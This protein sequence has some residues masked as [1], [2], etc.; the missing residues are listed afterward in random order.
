MQ[1]ILCLVA[2]VSALVRAQLL[3]DFSQGGWE[4]FASTPGTLVV[5]PGR[6]HLQDADEAPDW[7]TASKRFSVDLDRHPLFLVSV[8][9]LSDHGTVKLI[10]KN[11]DDKRTVLEMGSPGLYVIDLTKRFGW[12]GPCEIDVC[13][14]AVGFGESIDYAYVQFADKLSAE[15]E[16]ALK[17]REDGRNLKL[18]VTALEAVPLFNACAFYF[19]SPRR[20]SLAVSY[21]QAGGPWQRAFAPPYIAEDGM[22]RG[23]IVDL[24]ENTAY[25]LRIADGEGTVLAETAFRTWASEVPVART[26]VLD[27]TNFDGHLQIRE[28]GSPEGWIRYTA[29]PGFV[30]R[31]DRSG[32][33]L[34]LE[35][36][37]YILLDGLTLRGGLKEAI[38]IR[39]CE[40]VRVQ[41]CDIAGWGR[42]GTQ[43]FDRDGVFYTAEGA[44][45]NWDTAIL[46]SR[47]VGTV[48]E[49]CYV[50]DP[51]S[52]ANSWYYSH[53]AGPQAVGIDK[54]RSTVLRYNDFIGSDEHRWNDAVEGSGNFHQDG[55]FFR[56]ADIYGNLM[57]FAN[58]DAIEID[59]GQ[60]NVRVH[61]NL[62][63]GCLCGVSIQGCM[64]GPSYVF[65]N[66]LKN[67]GDERGVA[68]QT[69]K[70][71]SNGSGKSA[72]S[73]LFANSS[74][75]TGSD[76]GLLDHLRIVAKN[77]IFAGKR[78]ITG[79]Q[80]SPQSDCDYNLNSTGEA[81]DEP[82]GL[83]GLPEFADAA[84]GHF[85][86]A[87]GSNLLG[88]GV[89]IDNFV[90]AV[91]GRVDLGAIPAGSNL[92]LP[93][94]PIPVTLDRYELRVAEAD[95]LAGRSSTVTAAVGGEGFSSPFRIAKNEVFDW[96]TV[97]PESGTLTAGGR[98]TFTVTPVPGKAPARKHLRGAFLVRLENGFSRPVMVYAE[99]D[100]VPPV[101]PPAG[102][103]WIAYL[104]AEA[105]AGER[106][107]AVVD[108]PAASGGKC[109]LVAGSAKDAP[110][111]YRFQVPKDGS[112]IFLMRV[113][114]EESASPILHFSVD[115]G[116]QADSRLRSDTAWSWSMLAHNRQQRLTCHQ[117]FKLKAGE[118]VLRL[119]P[120]GSLYV[121]LIAVTD[122][123]GVFE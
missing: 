106:A 81:G 96:F 54:P 42:I 45:I 69:I 10:R 90:P 16:A 87:E 120:G 44:A 71:S 72:V 91:D 29:K 70:T 6:L 92:V 53:P 19:P 8:T 76:L 74:H 111:E 57:C 75:N 85:A 65:R 21:R 31:N 28:S 104:E 9:A 77:N 36:A 4:R 88:R 83:I 121:D 119:V 25:E 97:T 7:V 3:D 117:P 59:G 73:F 112:Y 84:A 38:A 37:K 56:D 23:S 34:E 39:R 61:R 2:L 58:D 98:V 79:R 47:S 66:L 51:V 89:A 107:F 13:L 18:N 113:R 33:L 30:L 12:K 99:T 80:R 101:K 86:P 62:F 102:D 26:V 94:R 103:A 55:G 40:Q 5:E 108:D 50:H 64:A 60:I 78:A 100:Y 27:E 52:T 43:R 63:E 11:P 49:R 48:V 35:R 17:E 32:P 46:V 20:D 41:N 15:Q 118:H 109:V 110:V 116:K 67:M 122:N 1:R 68:G 93:Y 114:S 123:P 105:P 95:F 14:Y 24:D 115:D 22:Y 82:N